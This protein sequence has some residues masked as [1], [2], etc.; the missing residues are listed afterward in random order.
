MYYTRSMPSCSSHRLHFT[1][2]QLI[3]S[4]R[5]SS[6]NFLSS[7]PQL[8]AP[9]YVYPILLIALSRGLRAPTSLVVP[10]L[11]ATQS[12][13]SS[14]FFYLWSFPLFFYRLLSRVTTSSS[15]FSFLSSS[16]SF[17]LLLLAVLFRLR[18]A[19]LL[20]AVRI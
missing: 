10:C 8:L 9:P 7:R 1:W 2:L 14:F 3:P 12:C 20:L 19:S 6:A 16:L 5:F 15:T 4:L 11:V 17:M 18:S 13:L